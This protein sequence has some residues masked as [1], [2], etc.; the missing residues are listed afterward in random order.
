MLHIIGMILKIIGIILAVILGILVLLICIVLF[1]PLRYQVDAGFSGTIESARVKVKCSW[2]LHLISA[3][4]DL[5]NGELKWRVRILHKKF[6]SELEA[7]EAEEAVE[8]VAVAETEEAVGKAEIPKMPEREK[9]LLQEPVV[10]VQESVEEDDATEKEPDTNETDVESERLLEPMDRGDEAE[11]ELKTH[12]KRKSFFVRIAEK[13]KALFEKINA[14]FKNIK[15]TFKKICD[16]IKVLMEKKE[17]VVEFIEDEVHILAFARLKK[18][19]F[20]LLKFL[21]PKKF[22]LRTRFGFEDP[23]HTG[24]ALALLSVIYPF[25]GGQLSVEPDFEERVLEG[26]L[27]I[28]GKIRAFYAVIMAWN[29]F[30]DKSVRKLYADVKRMSGK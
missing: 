12:R 20:R 25:V 2:L 8:E 5:E 18:E 7:Q 27:F 16:K 11:K 14:F 15:Y 1:V 9:P 30:W 26:E 21:K 3:S 22:Q 10:T 28:K 13:L 23:Y 4:A 6:G 19:A 24:Q 17:L 29:L